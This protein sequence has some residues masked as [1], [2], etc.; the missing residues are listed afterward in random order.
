[1]FYKLSE[2]TF[3]Y[4]VLI[5]SVIPFL[6]VFMAAFDKTPQLWITS[7]DFTLQNF[8]NLIFNVDALTWFMN[9]FIYAI[10]TLFLVLIASSL[11]GYTLSRI[12]VWWKTPFLYFILLIRI[13]PGT[14]YLVPR[15]KMINNLGLL[16]TYFSVILIDAAES[17]PI[18]LWIMKTFYDT[19]NRE[20]EEAVWIDGGNR[21]NSLTRVVFPLSLPAVAAVSILTF[22]SSW[23]T[24]LTP[25]LF[26]TSPSK[27]PLG[28]AI[29]R[30]YV[31]PQTIDFAFMAAL[32]IL[33]MLPAIALFLFFRKYLIKSFNIAG[34]S[35]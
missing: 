19:I 1:M 2:K 27:I 23:G 9:S 16:D 20:L 22:T 5:F 12:D 18:A 33:Y 29:Y 11:G 21:W 17:L 3:L 26:I 25:L 30:A 10:G 35:G 6:W 32:S 13:I 8:S 7:I 14:T 15:F 31:T 34:V 24:F 28:I 4:A